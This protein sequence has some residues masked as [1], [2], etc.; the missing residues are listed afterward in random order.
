MIEYD[1]NVKRDQ[2]THQLCICAVFVFLLFFLSSE[3]Y[4]FYSI[5]ISPTE[6]KNKKNSKANYDVARASVYA[7][8]I[9]DKVCSAEPYSHR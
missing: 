5:F 2:P 9:F 4:I 1:V 3:S 7:S 6:K 8:Y